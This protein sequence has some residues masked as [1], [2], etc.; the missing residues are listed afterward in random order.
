MNGYSGNTFYVNDPGYSKT[1]YDYSE[2][3]DSGAY[4]PVA[5]T[6]L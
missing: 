3:V 4:N 6:F 2:I 5:R 1:S